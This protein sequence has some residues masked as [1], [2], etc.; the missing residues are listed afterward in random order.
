MKQALAAAALTLLVS[1]GFFLWIAEDMAPRAEFV[2][3]VE[4]PQTAETD[5]LRAA[6]SLLHFRPAIETAGDAQCLACHREV[7][8]DRVRAASPSGLKTETLRAWYQETPTYAGEQDT[9]H[10]RHLVTPLAKR[11]MNLRCNTCH[12]GHDPREEA[13][14]AAADSA[15]MGDLA[16]LAVAFALAHLKPDGALLVKCFHGS[17]YSQIVELF[18][19]SFVT[20]AV[21]KPK[22][23]RDRSAET[24]LL[25]RSPKA[26]VAAGPRAAA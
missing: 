17:G 25:G 1:I 12:Q 2:A 22:A 5:H 26:G 7:I 21:R 16:E 19:R 10:R 4:A 9:F 8:E 13:Q 11:L 18:K 23:S 24:Y 20:V 6:Y 15:R 14:G 3:H